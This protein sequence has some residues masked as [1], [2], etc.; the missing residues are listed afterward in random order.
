[1]DGEQ[2]LQLQ[3]RLPLLLQTFESDETAN[4]AADDDRVPM[5]SK[6]PSMMWTSDAVVA[7]ARTK[8]SA[9]DDAGLYDENGEP[10]VPTMDEDFRK[11]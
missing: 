5:P 11:C 1:M 3:R 7:V 10:M 4:V 8:A 2:R 9:D 6:M